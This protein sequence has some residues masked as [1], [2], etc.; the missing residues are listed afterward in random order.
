MSTT[1]PDIDIILAPLRLLVKAQA[2]IV[3]ELKAAGKPELDIKKAVTE[4]KARK[5]VLEEKELELR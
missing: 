1:E 2:D 5:R 4:L 3:R